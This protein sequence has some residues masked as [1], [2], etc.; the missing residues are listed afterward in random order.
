MYIYCR[1]GN[2]RDI[3]LVSNLGRLEE[4]LQ[5]NRQAI[6]H[7][8]NQTNKQTFFLPLPLSL[9]LPPQSSRVLSYHFHRLPRECPCPVHLRE[10]PVSEIC[11]GLR[12]SQELELLLRKGRGGERRKDKKTAK[13]SSSSLCTFPSPPLRRSCPP[14]PNITSTPA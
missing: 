5:Q 12:Q 6:E 9:S 1:G 7:S 3:I 13:D 8:I 10:G 14:P 2:G 4:G 11:T